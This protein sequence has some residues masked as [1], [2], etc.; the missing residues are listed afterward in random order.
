[1]QALSK[2]T[3]TAL[4]IIL[5][6]FFVILF[7]TLNYYFVNRTAPNVRIGNVSLAN[8][9]ISDS[10]ELIAAETNTFSH[11]PVI[12]Y[13]EGVTVESDL[14]SLGIKMNEGETLEIVKRLGKSPDSWKNVVF[15]LESL[16]ISRQISPQYSLDIS[17]FTETTGAILSEFETQYRDAAITFKNGAFEIQKEQTG[18]VINREKMANDIKKNIQ[19]LSNS[20]VNL[21]MVSAEPAIKTSQAQRV[22][23]KITDFEKRNIALV[24]NNQKWQISGKNL[25][26]MLEFQPENQ[27]AA[28]YIKVSLVSDAFVIKSTRLA[29]DPEPQLRVILSSNKIDAF[30][31]SISEAID[32]KTINAKLRFEGGKVVEFTPAQD[33]QELDIAKTNK[34]IYESLFDSDQDFAKTITITLPVSTTRAKVEGDGVGNLGIR[35]L[36]GRGISY[37]SGSIANRIHNISLGAGRISGTIVAPGEVFSFNNSVGEVSAATG[38]RQAYVISSGKTVLDDGGGIC[39]VSTTVF[40]AAL[41]AGLP[42]V[43]RTAHSYRVGY[44]EQGGYKPGIDATVF[45]PAVDFQFKNDTEHHVLVQTV[46]D[47]ANAKLQVDFYGTGDDRKVEISQPVVS[48]ITPAPADRYQDDPTLPKGTVKQVDFSAQGAISVFTRKVYKG[49]KLLIDDVFKSNYRPWQAV[50][51]VGTG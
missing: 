13:I 43:K 45:A 5:G 9:K 31:E 15:W 18:I 25:A 20:P 28:P 48:N 24:N 44:Y 14:Q 21:Q 34:L 10:H 39:Q 19:S 29:I 40:R 38:Y 36:V 46:V 1:M 4:V 3:L 16:F 41:D 47:R 17:K 33:G 11:S 22:L 8:K 23:E 12:F 51:L 37:F 42:I 7:G 50:F 2:K 26:D 35:E 27:L 32:I 49:D 6:T 30:V